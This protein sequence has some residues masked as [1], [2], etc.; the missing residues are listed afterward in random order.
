M[1]SSESSDPAIVGQILGCDIDA[2]ALLEALPEAALIAT[3]AGRITMHNGM[4]ERL[5]ADGSS[6]VG[7]DVHALLPLVPRGPAHELQPH[8]WQETLGN[9]V[10]PHQVVEVSCSP[11]VRRGALPQYVYILH[12]ISRQT[13]LNWWREQ[14]LYQVAHEIRGSLGIM[15]TA[16]MWWKN[17][18]LGQA[19][20]E[21]AEIRSAG[22]QAIAG[23]ERLFQDLLS[24]GS[25][26]AGRLQVKPQATAVADLLAGAQAMLAPNLETSGC[27]I[28]VRVFPSDPWV[29]ADVA[30]IGRVL[31]NLLM[32][33]TTHS[34][35]GGNVTLEVREVDTGQIC[36]AVEDRGPGI[37]MEE[38]P[39]LFERFYRVND[40][41][42]GRIDL[43]LAI[44]KG[45]VEAHAG[46]I[47]LTSAPGHGTRVWFTLPGV[48]EPVDDV[49]ATR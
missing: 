17:H 23:V 4:A 26:R 38:Q 9:D 42:D 8:R 49:T 47:G 45:I 11:V 7:K 43:G 15:N 44:A 25:I 30:A 33:A 13:E 28:D 10:P 14:L 36:F 37:T 32:N 2:R 31:V 20:P 41:K 35:R 34:P 40:A 16:L 46:S 24:A 19:T 21:S 48:R 6:L 12:D 39:W 3:G 1:M 27:R 5:F 22:T 18:E 29:M